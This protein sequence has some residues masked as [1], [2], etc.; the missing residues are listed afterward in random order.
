MVNI[1]KLNEDPQPLTE[2][3]ANTQIGESTDCHYELF[4]NPQKNDYR[5]IL[6]EE[7]YYLCAYCNRNLDEYSTDDKLHLL[8]I[9]HWFPQTLCQKEK[10][11]NTVDGRDIS[12]RNM[13]L[14]CPGNNV[15]PDFSHCDTSR[16]PSKVLT[17]E[18]QHDTYKFENVFTYEGGKLLT[19]NKAIEND[20]NKELNLND[21]MLI[22][23]RNIILGQFRKLIIGNKIDKKILLIKYSSANKEKRKK[24]YCTV[25]LYYINKEL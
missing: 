6:L 16:T 13:L 11:Y 4:Q 17:I 18:P 15:N 25:L 8:K 23:R 3:K 5:K 1:V 22:H 20:I 2:F 10:V 7:Q 24:E 9:E 14:V 12:H 21:D 19:D